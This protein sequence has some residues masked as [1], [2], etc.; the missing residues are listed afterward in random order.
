MV[1]IGY[2]GALFLPNDVFQ[3]QINEMETICRAF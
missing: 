3:P 2:N 1:K